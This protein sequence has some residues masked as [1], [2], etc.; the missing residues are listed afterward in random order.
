MGSN[1]A[2]SAICSLFLARNGIL[3][4]I[5]W[6]CSP[7]AYIID[8]FGNCLSLEGVWQ[9]ICKSQKDFFQKYVAYHY[10]RSRGWV[11]KPG[12]KF[13]GDFRKFNFYMNFS[14]FPQGGKCY[15]LGMT[16]SQRPLIR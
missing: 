16:L 11:V 7:S 9:L 5:W 13:G 4:S 2:D 1:H 8:L 14:S 6:E 15:L 12:I 3:Q 10:F